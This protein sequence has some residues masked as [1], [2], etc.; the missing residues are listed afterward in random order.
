MSGRPVTEANIRNQLIKPFRNMPR[1]ESITED[2]LKAL[3]EY[4]KTL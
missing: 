1:I 4:L 2:K 3:F